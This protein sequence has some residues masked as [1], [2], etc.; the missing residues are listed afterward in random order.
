MT[1]VADETAMAHDLMERIDT[2]ESVALSLP[3]QDGRRKALLRLAEKDLAGAAPF[4]PRIAAE[5]L[6]LSE[7]TVRAWIAEGVL[8]RVESESV[9]VL[10]DVRR[11]HQVLRLVQQLRAAGKTSGLLDEVHRRLVDET[12]LDREDLLESLSQMR[13]GYG[14]TRIAKDLP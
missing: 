5:L 14:I 2:L 13:Q 1:A 3:E 12:W 9:R 10:L 6:N 8:L 11:V 7:K 4:R